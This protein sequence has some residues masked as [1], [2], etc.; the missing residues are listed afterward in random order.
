LQR[1][2][3]RVSA[4]PEAID[5]FTSLMAMRQK[6][7]AQDYYAIGRA[8]YFTRQ[9]TEADAAFLKLIELQPNMSVGYLWEARTKSN[10]DPESEEGL[11]RPYYEKLI[12]KA[13]VN[14]EKGKQ[15]LIEAYSYLG[16][17]HFI[18]AENA[19]ARDYWAKVIALNP[20]DEKAK[21]ALKALN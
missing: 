2:F 19:L 1:L 7:T 21:E 8:Y 17:Y 12:E 3:S 13:S 20:N 16:Y 10:L 6:P 4:I 14:P 18:K 9:F 11:A 15:D 5:A